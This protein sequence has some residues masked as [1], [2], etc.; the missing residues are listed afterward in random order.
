MI[1]TGDVACA[2]KLLQPARL[3]LRAGKQIR[4]EPFERRV[5]LWNEIK[6][7]QERFRREECGMFLEEVDL[8]MRS[9]YDAALVALAAGF[10]HN[11]EEFLQ[12]SAYTGTE[13]ALWHLMERYNILEILPQDELR[14]RLLKRDGDLLGLFHDYYLTMNRYVAATLED[15]EIRLTLRYYLRRRWGRY[16]GKMDAAIAEAIMKYDWMQGLVAEWEKDR[17]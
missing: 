5:G 17:T 11:K 16:R 6:Q 12:A 8:H 7:N 10:I 3:V 4:F 1:P 13:I 14:N 2:E 9:Q 15:P